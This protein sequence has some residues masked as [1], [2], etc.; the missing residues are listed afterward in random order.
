MKTDVLRY[1]A[2]IVLAVALSLAGLAIL[3]GSAVANSGAG[4]VASQSATLSTGLVRFNTTDIRYAD[5][6]Y[7]TER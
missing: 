4:P 7:R 3:G 6:M 2:C 1:T 5:P